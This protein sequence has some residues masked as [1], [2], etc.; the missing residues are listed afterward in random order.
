MREWQIR[1]DKK[2]LADIETRLAALRAEQQSPA[3]R[4][5]GLVGAR[6]GGGE[7]S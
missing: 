6:A 3:A 5:D 7:V 2:R 1:R 4:R